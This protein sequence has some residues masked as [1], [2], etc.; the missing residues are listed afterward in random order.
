MAG[1]RKISVGQEGLYIPALPW[2][3]GSVDLCDL[4]ENGD[5][6]RN[7]CRDLF[8]SLHSSFPI[9]SVNISFFCWGFPSTVETMRQLYIRKYQTV[10]LQ[11]LPYTQWSRLWFTTV[12]FAS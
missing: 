11:F 6:T 10:V 9:Y 1:E 7:E 5:N 8:F 12:F 3:Y 2:I 4:A